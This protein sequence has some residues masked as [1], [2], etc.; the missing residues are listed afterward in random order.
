ML[1]F[2]SATY[3]PHTGTNMPRIVVSLIVAAFLTGSAHAAPDL[4]GSEKIETRTLENGLK[5]IV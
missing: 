5:I 3:N 1:G 2:V 4:A